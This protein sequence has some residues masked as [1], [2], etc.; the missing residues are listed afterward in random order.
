VTISSHISNGISVHDRSQ[1]FLALWLPT[2][3][4]VDPQKLSLSADGSPHQNWWFRIK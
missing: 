2:L 4:M 1:N 3:G